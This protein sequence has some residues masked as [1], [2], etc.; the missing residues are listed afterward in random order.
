MNDA[1]SVQKKKPPFRRSKK[2]YIVRELVEAMLRNKR[3]LLE[4]SKNMDGGYRCPLDWQ[5][6]SDHGHREISRILV[7]TGYGSYECP[8]CGQGFLS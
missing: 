6:D 4:F 3:L 1:K 5:L 8:F 7:T 2:D